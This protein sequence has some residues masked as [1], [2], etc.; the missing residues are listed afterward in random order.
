M[1]RTYRGFLITAECTHLATAGRCLTPNLA[2]GEIAL[3]H[4]NN[5]LELATNSFRV[6]KFKTTSLTNFQRQHTNARCCRY[7]S[8]AVL[9]LRVM[10]SGT[11]AQEDRR[12]A[13]ALPTVHSDPPSDRAGARD[14]DPDS[15]EQSVSPCWVSAMPIKR[16]GLGYSAIGL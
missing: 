1:R 11:L 5:L 7:H 8:L 14:L 10:K 16:A 3:P 4:I 15:Q 2:G 6:T 9:A 13:L 12:Q